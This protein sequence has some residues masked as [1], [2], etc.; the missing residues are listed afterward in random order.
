ITGGA[1]ADPGTA[2]IQSGA[3]VQSGQ[4]PQRA[5]RAAGRVA[6]AEHWAAAA[7][8]LLLVTVCAGLGHGRHVL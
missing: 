6:Q 1:V 2:A 7:V 8:A 4:G 3:D 5:G